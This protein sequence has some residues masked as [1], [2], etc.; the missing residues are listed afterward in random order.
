MS[1]QTVGR[2]NTAARE[3]L[4][5]PQVTS[6]KW[7]IDSNPWKGMDPVYLALSRLRRQRLDESMAVATD[8]LARNPYD[9]QVWW[10]KCRGLTNKNWMDDTEIEEEGIAEMLLD[11]NATAA[12]PRPGTSL[13][14]PQ[15]NSNG[16]S[17]AVR[18]T[19]VGGRPLSGFAR[20]GTGGQRPGSGMSVE[21]AVASGRM[22]TAMNRP[23]TTSGRFVRL[24]TASMLSEP[25]GAFVNLDKIN[26]HKYA[27]RPAMSKALC[28]YILYVE[29]Q[30][31][32]A[33]ELGAAATQRAS[34][35]D[36]WWKARL[37]KAYYQLG[38]HRE[39]ERQFLSSLK[40]QDMVVT[41]LEL[42]KIYVKLDQP[43]KAIQIYTNAAKAHPFETALLLAAAR[44]HEALNNGD[45]GM[46]L[47]KQVL[48][49]EAS[50]V[51]A[52]SCLAAHQ[53]YSDQP[54]IALRYYRRLLQMGVQTAEL[55]NNLGL[56]CFYS[57]Q[58]DMCLTCFQRALQLA[59]EDTTA[60]TW[61]NISHLAVGIGDL[62]LSY[63]A[64]K[65]A[66]AADSKHAEAYN[67]LSVLELKK[68]NLDAARSGFN[69]AHTLNPSMFEAPFNSALLC[70]KL[71][72]SQE[73]F[74]LVNKSLSNFPGHSESKELLKML[75]QKF[76]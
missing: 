21:Q 18:P 27:E 20:P 71:G 75:E 5:A 7:N 73:S 33:I 8:L 31:K 36:W 74:N 70:Y 54:E 19:S 62:G 64:L 53:F 2:L 35:R 30:P 47:Y 22:G 52:V 15:T 50:N 9:Q 34:F 12:L 23:V 41:H 40:D 61:Y 32:K 3:T 38:M 26:V 55:W 28:D 58:Y 11:D 43:N 24:G 4:A 65:V 49:I 13:N 67:N 29:H 25:G 57:G 39:A 10:V 48:Q 44:V 76:A 69:Q 46:A 60:D 51:E 42:G 14:R 37:G 72:E 16:P 59:G 68:G 17:P 56:C 63:Q 1:F 66:V 45:E 6:D